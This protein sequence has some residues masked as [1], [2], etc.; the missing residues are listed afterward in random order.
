MRSRRVRFTPESAAQAE[1]I[2]RWWRRHRPASPDLFAH[3]LRDAI[4]LLARA[5]GA[6]RVYQTL[7]LAGVR[8]VL[9]HGVRSHVYFVVRESFV[10]IVAVWSAR[11]GE[12]PPL[13]SFPF[14]H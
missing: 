10:V 1:A 11:R 5:P 6:G 7:A 12:G 3:E 13:G 2:D 4:K 9:L 14:T 8:R